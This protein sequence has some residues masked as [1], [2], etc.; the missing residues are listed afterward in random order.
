MNNTL[1]KSEK[2]FKDV[3]NKKYKDKSII[4]N[5]IYSKEVKNQLLDLYYLIL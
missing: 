3:D 1:S 4:D 5:T 2:K